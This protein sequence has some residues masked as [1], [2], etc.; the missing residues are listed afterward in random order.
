MVSDGARAAG[1]IHGYSSRPESARLVHAAHA[2]FAATGTNVWFEYVPTKANA[3]DEP[4]RDIGL[5]RRAYRPAEGLVSVPVPLRL[6][7]V[8]ALAELGAWAR[9]AKDLVL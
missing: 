3:A 2:W 7:R 6:P 4:S 1:G 9:A 5:A 8:E